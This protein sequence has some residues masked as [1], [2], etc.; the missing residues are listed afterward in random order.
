MNPYGKG[1]EI[2]S[3]WEG[4]KSHHVSRPGEREMPTEHIFVYP[5]DRLN[6]NGSQNIFH[7]FNLDFDREKIILNG[8]ICQTRMEFLKFLI[9]YISHSRQLD[10][11]LLM[12]QQTMFAYVLNDLTQM[13]ESKGFDY[14][15][16]DGGESVNIAFQTVKDRRDLIIIVR[17]D[18]LLLDPVDPDLI[19]NTVQLEIIS[20]SLFDPMIYVYVNF[21]FKM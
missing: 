2:I 17:K 19:I 20:E 11:V 16:V 6:E 15:L 10:Q 3:I 9:P 13:M 18:M 5:K 1:H 21:Q 4:Q 8:K 7:Q 12:C 14:L